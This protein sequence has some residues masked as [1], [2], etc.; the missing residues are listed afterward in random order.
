MA[1]SDFEPGG[2]IYETNQR[3]YERYKEDAAQRLQF[4]HDFAQTSLQSSVLVNGGAIVALFT[5]LGHDKAVISADALAWSFG[6]FVAALACGLLAH[7]GAFLSQAFY[8]QVAEYDAVA[9]RNAM[10]KLTNIA[11]HDEGEARARRRGHI[12]FGVALGASAL[13]LVGFVLGAWCALDGVR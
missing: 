7:L 10:G 2:F 1:D 6:W 5:F 8:M 9:A 12:A 11:G 3:D 4:Q 13:S